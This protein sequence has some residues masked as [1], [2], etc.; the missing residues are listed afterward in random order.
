MIRLAF[1]HITY[2]VLQVIDRL[3]LTIDTLKT[4]KLGKIVVRLVKEPPAPGTRC[5]VL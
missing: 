5:F 3:P 1:P 4:S 2:V